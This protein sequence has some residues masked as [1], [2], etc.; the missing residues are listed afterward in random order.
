MTNLNTNEPL[1]GIPPISRAGG[2]TAGAGIAL[3]R[4]AGVPVSARWSVLVVLALFAEVLATSALPAARPHEAVGAYWLAGLLTAAVFLI[5]VVAH[6]VA[7]AVTARHY[8]MRVKG[9]TLW[10]LGGV[11]ELEG[12][13]PSPRAEALIAVAGPATSIGLGA[14]SAALAWSVAGSGLPGAALGWLGGV[15]IFL[16]V[17]NLLPAAPLDGGRLL[18]AL[19]WRHYNDRARAGY[20][21]AR[22]GRALGFVLIALGLAELI[23]TGSLAGVWLGLVGW[24]IVGS[25]TL[26]ARVSQATG[27]AG[28]RVADVMTSQPTVLADWWTVDQVLNGM[29]ADSGAA[30]Q[31]YPLVDFAGSSA[32]A[33]T[34][35]DL[36]QI[37]V[38]VRA[39][40][41][42]RDIVRSRRVR[43]LV[44]RPE[45]ILSDVAL[46]L[47][48]HAGIAIVVDDDGHPIGIVTTNDLTRPSRSVDLLD[49]G[50]S[51]TGREPGA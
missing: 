23:L 42:V 50:R 15:S 46:Q 40:T 24:F 17:F 33:V 22:I 12:E 21:A 47:R 8:R 14:I 4:W 9:I 11:T 3:G 48:Q 30:A 1:Q 31:I 28:L 44:V 49:V 13:S 16:G 5:T 7:H 26:E 36:D 27:L 20:R 2:R 10:M 18:R 29:S 45:T 51:G 41:R 32:G 19:L 43:P 6:E 37:P 25:A 34:R 38:G 39:D 35:R